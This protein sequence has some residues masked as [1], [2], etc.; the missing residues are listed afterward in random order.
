MAA[1]DPALAGERYDEKEEGR[2]EDP[3]SL[4]RVPDQ[5]LTDTCAVAQGGHLRVAGRV[6]SGSYFHALCTRKI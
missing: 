3:R 2:A 5:F 6:R 4:A 1:R